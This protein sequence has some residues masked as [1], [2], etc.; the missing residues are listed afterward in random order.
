MTSL[1]YMTV[2]G[3]PPAVQRVI[4]INNAWV[5]RTGIR[6]FSDALNDWTP[7]VGATDVKVRLSRSATGFTFEGYPSTLLGPFTMLETSDAGWYYFPI[8]ADLITAAL[9]DLVGQ[10]IYQII[11]GSYGQY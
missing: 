1:P 8:G 4:P 10:T 9:K 2:R 6:Y 3:A 5:A 7:Y 11:E